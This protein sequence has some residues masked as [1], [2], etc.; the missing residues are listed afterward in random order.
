MSLVG[1]NARSIIKS[2]RGLPKGD[3][4]ELQLPFDE[5]DPCCQKEIINENHHARVGAEL[6]KHDRTLERLEAQKRAIN[7]LRKGFGCACGEAC[8]MT[9][10]DYALLAMLREAKQSFVDSQDNIIGENLFQDSEGNYSDSDDDSLLN[11]MDG[12][13]LTSEERARLDEAKQLA[14]LRE[15]A[16]GM[17]YARHIEE[18]FSH[19]RKLINSKQIVILHIY[20]GSS[21]LCARLDLLMEKLAAI[22][23]GT[24]FR[25]MS[26]SPESYHFLE[27]EVDR[28]LSASAQVL[29]PRLTRGQACLVA[30]R[31]GAVSLIENNLHQFGS[32]DEVFEGE[33]L[34]YLSNAHLLSSDLVLPTLEALL[35]E[36]NGED[37]EEEEDTYVC[38]FPGCVRGYNHSHVAAGA[39]SL[40]RNDR[41][42]GLE[43]LADNIFTKM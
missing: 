16:Q 13:F 31:D 29:Q 30:F 34:R 12:E 42:Q 37:K 4:T 27:T 26:L 43:A 19:C 35:G 5:L 38:S 1:E 25:R 21:M 2:T 14:E 17:G 9:G 11:D 7:S 23:I 20:D 32:D 15:K 10:Y 41:E 28:G 6:R 8:D 22:Y 18:D 36:G 40:V 39:D 24:K 3:N 33:L